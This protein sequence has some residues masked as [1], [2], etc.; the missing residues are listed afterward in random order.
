MLPEFK[1]EITFP[2]SATASSWE[3]IWGW[4][5][6]FAAWTSS[7]VIVI[8]TISW[9]PRLPKS[10]FPLIPNTYV[11]CFFVEVTFYVSDSFTFQVFIFFKKKNQKMLYVFLI[12]F[13]FFKSNCRKFRQYSRNL[14][15]AMFFVF[16]ARTFFVNRPMRSKSHSKRKMACILRS[17]NEFKNWFQIQT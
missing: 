15:S 16:I 11:C 3:W 13:M 1:N 2:I 9:A 14:S 17:L 6:F 10:I 5:L 4:R 12:F 8:W 7:A